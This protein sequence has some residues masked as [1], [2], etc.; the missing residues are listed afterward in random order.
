MRCICPPD[1]ADVAV[2][3]S[4]QPDSG[5]RLQD[6]VARALADAAPKSGRSPEPGADEIEHRDRETAVNIHGLRQIGD[7]PVVEAV[8]SDHAGERPEDAGHPAEQR[9]LAGA[10]RTDH[11][12]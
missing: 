9:R 3:E 6:P 4:V 10:V 1:S 8:D 2:L 5:E 11:G 7:I 12:Q